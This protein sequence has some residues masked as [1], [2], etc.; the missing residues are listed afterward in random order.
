[1]LDC[2]TMRRRSVFILR[3]AVAVL[4]G[5]LVACATPP[6]EADVTAVLESFYGAMGRGDAAA[7]MNLIA[8][9]AMF[10]ESG[11]L[12]TRDEYEKNH[13]PADINFERQVKGVRGPMR[14]TFEGDTAWVIVSTEFK[15]TFDGSPV[16]FISSQLAV[17]TRDTGEWLIRSI[18]WSSRRP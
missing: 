1:M 10:I 7:A 12:E 11:R 13:L 15:G 5:S 6:S 14:V 18:H 8:P 2:A 17:L 4:S 9:D 16:D 3:L